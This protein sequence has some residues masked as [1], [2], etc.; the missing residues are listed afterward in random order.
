MEIQLTMQNSW[1][2]TKRFEETLTMHSKSEPILIFMGSNA[3]NVI[4]KLFN[5]LL[6][7]FQQLQEQSN[8]RGSKF[9]CDSIELLYYLFQ[10]VDI[11]RAELYMMSPD[12]IVS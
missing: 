4:N 5:T 8:E 7:G 11:R 9:I 2:S 10:R 6:Q 3:E 12:W 1:I